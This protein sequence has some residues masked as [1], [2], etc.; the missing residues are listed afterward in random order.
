MPF[1]LG[2]LQGEQAHGVEEQQ[3][4]ILSTKIRKQWG[5][6]DHIPESLE[7]PPLT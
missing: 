2:I 6:G 5:P 3:A 1:G 4:K 7:H